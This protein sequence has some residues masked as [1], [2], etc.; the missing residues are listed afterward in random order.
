MPFVVS[1]TCA[2]RGLKVT[3]DTT[4]IRYLSSVRYQTIFVYESEIRFYRWKTLPMGFSWSPWVAQS[5][6]M[7]VL[8]RVAEEIEDRP[9]LLYQKAITPPS[10]I[11]T[12]NV[13]AAAWYGNVL[14]VVANE[15]SSS[16][17]PEKIL[18]GRLAEFNIQLK[19]LTLF[20][21]FFFFFFLG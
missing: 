12:K 10:F 18:R 4:S 2:Y 17:S 9:L 13:F 19:S 3:S 1:T 16:K 21:F 5:I 15:A 11:R 14:L 20:F 6:T 8:L 7:G